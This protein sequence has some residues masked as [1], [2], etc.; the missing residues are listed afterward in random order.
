M[1]PKVIHYCWFG[2]NPKPKLAKKCFKSWEKYCPDY[3]IIEWNE[4]NYSLNDAPLYV[5]QAYEAKKWAFVTD[6]VRLQIIY[7]HGGV[8]FDTDVELLRPI[9]ELLCNCAYFG[10]EEGSYVNTGLGFGAEKG[11][12]I[13]KK[14][15][16]DYE[17]IPYVKEDGTYDNTTCPHRNTVVFLKNG[18]KQDDSMQQLEGDVIV[19]PTEYLCPKDWKTGDLKITD[20]TYSIHHCSAS[21]Y[22]AEMQ[23]KRKKYQREEWLRHLPSTIGNKLIGKENYDKLRSKLKR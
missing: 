6:Y 4:S 5:Q 22:T 17:Q 10:F 18:L 23:K 3:E 15:M 9:D 2:E 21:W 16:D 19:L 7:E 11:T 1:I 13:L 14:M 12:G 8:Y 20:K